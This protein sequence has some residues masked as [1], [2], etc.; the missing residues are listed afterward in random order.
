MGLV[1]VNPPPLDVGMTVETAGGRVRIETVGMY[2]VVGLV[3]VKPP[4]VCVGMVTRVVGIGGRYGGSVGGLG[5]T[6]VVETEVG[7]VLV[8]PP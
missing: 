3:L 6:Y 8:N 4:P 2:G 1:L 7:L 5:S